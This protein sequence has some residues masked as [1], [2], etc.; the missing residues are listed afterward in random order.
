MPSRVMIW[1]FGEASITARV[2]TFVS[3]IVAYIQSLLSLRGVALLGFG[4]VSH[5][6]KGMDTGVELLD[7]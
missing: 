1:E 5:L 3:S 2:Q 4:F 7:G 6:S